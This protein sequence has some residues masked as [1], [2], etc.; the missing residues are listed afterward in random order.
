M[1][2]AFA[3][4]RTLGRLGKWLRLMGFD[5]I[6]E[7]EFPRGAFG[8]HLTGDRRFLTRTRSALRTHAVL[9]PIFVRANDPCEQ[10]LEVI[11]QTGIHP[12]DLRLFSRCLRCNEPIA[13]V[14]KDSVLGLVPDYV[15][16]THASF[17]RCPGCR[18]V[19]WPG[20]HTARSSAKIERIFKRINGISSP[21][22]RS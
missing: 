3:V 17:S 4:E 6:L 11:R 8:A 10:L 15:W 16:E 22:H 18:R 21:S 9:R 12:E 5:T 14:P 20:S 13:P 7:T 1:P 2:I 19:Y